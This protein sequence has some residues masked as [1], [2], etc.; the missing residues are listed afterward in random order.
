MPAVT[1]FDSQEEI[2]EDVRDKATEVEG[3]FHVPADALVANYNKALGEKKD[4]DKQ[5]R[6]LRAQVEKYKDID[7]EKAREALDKIEQA[8]AE[9]LRTQGDWDAR[10]TALKQGFDTEKQTLQGEITNR[11]KALDKFVIFNELARCAQLPEIKGV[12]ELLEPHIAPFVR[13]KG[14]TDYEILDAS[15][16][17]RYGNDGQPLRMEAYLKEL[18]EHPTLSRLFDATGASGSGAAADIARGSGKRPDKDLR[19]SKMSS[20]EQDDY[21]RQY[22]YSEP[23]VKGVPAYKELPA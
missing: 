2:P 3:K 9:R 19:R 12:A 16:T 15:G 10:E 5:L 8:E 7:P 11:D 17:V 13:R 23:K 1:I 22:G 20:R 4:R 18:R 6:D 14:L 21:V